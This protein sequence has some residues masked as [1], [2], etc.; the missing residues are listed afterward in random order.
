METAI[1]KQS[2][3][4]EMWRILGNQNGFGE[5]LS[6]DSLSQKGRWRDKKGFIVKNMTPPDDSPFALRGD[7]PF[8]RT[9]DLPL[10]R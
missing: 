3:V 6:T 8:R 5:D 2:I 4:I 9:I 1:N 10:S 7:S